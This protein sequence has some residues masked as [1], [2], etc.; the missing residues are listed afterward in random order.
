MIQSIAVIVQKWKKQKKQI[1]FKS[2][3]HYL[4]LFFRKFLETLSLEVH[5][6]QT[7][8]ETTPAQLP[9]PNPLHCDDNAPLAPFMS[10][11]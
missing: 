3:S 9:T 7:K 8:H 1:H 5:I 2:Q 10:T 11:G 6:T 4:I